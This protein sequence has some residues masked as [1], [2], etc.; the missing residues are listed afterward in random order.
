MTKPTIHDRIVINVRKNCK[1]CGVKRV[2]IFTDQEFDRMISE[3]VCEKPRFDSL[4]MIAEKVLKPS[5]IKWC[6]GGVLKGRTTP[7]DLMNDIHVK[8]LKGVVTGFVKKDCAEDEINRDPDGFNSW[9]FKVAKNVVRD[10]VKAIK[11]TTGMDVD[12]DTVVNLPSTVDR[13]TAEETELNEQMLKESFAAVLDSDRKIYIVLTWLAQ[14]LFLIQFDIKRPQATDLILREF[15]EKSL[16]EMWKLLLV[17]SERVSWLTITPRQRQRISTALCTLMKDGTLFGELKYESFFM[18][19]GG[20]KTI[21]DWVNRID[22]MVKDR[23]KYGS[24]DNE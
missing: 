13:Y 15:R 20:K 4:S 21:S 10:T 7:E 12:I 19:K 8:L 18:K 1:K 24:F 23:M 16:F 17:F 14:S 11:R 2:R 3:I 22:T 5:V 6:R 9:L